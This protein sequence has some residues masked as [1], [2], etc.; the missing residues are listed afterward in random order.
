MIVFVY[1][2]PHSG[3]SYY[4]NN[5]ISK[6][7]VVIDEAHN[8]DFT[9]YKF[10]K[11]NDYFIIVQDLILLESSIK[12]KADLFVLCEFVKTDSASGYFTSKKYN[13]LKNLK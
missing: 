11:K 2:S 12:N 9:N 6:D 7:K 1:G 5:F 4:V 8:F 13:D 3:K 10:F